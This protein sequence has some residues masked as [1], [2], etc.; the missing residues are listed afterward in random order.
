MKAATEGIMYPYNAL[1]ELVD[2]KFFSNTALSGNHCTPYEAEV[3]HAS[4]K[5][6]KEELD[7]FFPSLPKA[8]R[9]FLLAPLH[10]GPVIGEEQ[11]F[12]VCTPEDGR[13][14]TD[15]W[16]IELKLPEEF[17]GL[18]KP[19]LLERSDDMCSEEHSLE[20]IAPYIARM[21]QEGGRT[22]PVTWFLAPERSPLLEEIVKIVRIHFPSAIILISNNCSTNCAAMWKEALYGSKQD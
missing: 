1:K 4:W 6:C 8:E 3:P 9:I 10:K 2:L 19:G 16:G 22:I 15:S 13:L 11:C 18:L 5:V 14:E 20:V 21:Q 17:N 12:A 7:N